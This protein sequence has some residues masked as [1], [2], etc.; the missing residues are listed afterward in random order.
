[1]TAA[2]GWHDCPCG[3]QEI[4]VF[5]RGETD[6]T[7]T[8]LKILRREGSGHDAGLRPEGNG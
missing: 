2:P 7:D 1:M 6:A 4:P 8:L 3:W 5:V